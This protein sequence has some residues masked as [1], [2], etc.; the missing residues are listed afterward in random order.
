[1]SEEEALTAGIT[2][3]LR[4]DKGGAE[5]IWNTLAGGSSARSAQ[6]AFNLGLLLEE[7]GDRDGAG[8]AYQLAIDSGHHDLAPRAGVNLGRL[9]KEEGDW[10][11]AKAAY[12]LGID[13]GHHDAAPV[14][15]GLLQGL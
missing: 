15:K 10:Y 3:Y 2:A 6:A 14:A 8:A 11:G 4:G 12:Q 5:H 13:S 9:L 1:L 7:E